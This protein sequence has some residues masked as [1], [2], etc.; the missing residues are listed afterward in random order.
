MPPEGQNLVVEA[1]FSEGRSERLPVLAAELVQLK[2]DVIVAA[3]YAADAA[4]GATSTIPIVMTNHPDPVG[5]GLVASL[6]RPGGNVTGLTGLAP[7]LVRKQLELL[8]QALPEFSRAVVLSNPANPAQS[9]ALQEARI[10]GETLK[11]R[12]LFLEARVRANIIGALSVATKQSAGAL[13]VVGDP[14]FFGERARIAELAT[15]GRLPLASG[16]SEFAEAGGLL[17]YGMDQ[18]DS[19]RRAATYVDKILKGARPAD[20]PVEQATKFELVINLK[21]AK[22]LGLTIQPSL[23]LRAD[24]VIE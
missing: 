5:S 14:M 7:N 23:L 16:Q 13:L 22:T 10:A 24:Q 6:A 11:V 19:F 12:L 2:V 3:V 21:T 18:R 17:T 9:L 1:R 15:K 20:L 8:K 4:K